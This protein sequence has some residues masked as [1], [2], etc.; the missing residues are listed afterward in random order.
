MPDARE[1]SPIVVTHLD[2]VRFAAQ[3]RSHVL[4]VD[5]PPHAGGMDAG[6]MPIELLGTSLGTCIALYVQQF[7]HARRLPYQGMRVEVEQIGAKNPNRVGEFSVRVL[8]PAPL[9]PAYGELLERVIRSCPAHNTLEH[10]ARL[11]IAIES[12]TAAAV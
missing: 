8:L 12:G 11:T 6:P 10:A 7:L 3:I 9:P 1:G 2:G 5:Q 4:I